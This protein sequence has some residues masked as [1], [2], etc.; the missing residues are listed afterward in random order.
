M[1]VQK[2]SGAW[3][4][5][6]NNRDFND[7]PFIG[8][9]TGHAIDGKVV[10]TQVLMESMTYT[11]AL[12]ILRSRTTHIFST[13]QDDRS[14]A[15]PHPVSFSEPHQAGWYQRYPLDGEMQQLTAT[16]AAHLPC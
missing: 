10:L 5:Y 13:K 2:G 12:D 7:V 4:V 15:R 3:L 14:K 1:R 9:W 11:I 8:L 6:N 16:A